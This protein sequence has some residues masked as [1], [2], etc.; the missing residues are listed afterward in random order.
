MFIREAKVEDAASLLDLLHRLDRESKFML[1]EPGERETTL[2]EQKAILESFSNSSSKTMLIACEDEQVVGFVIGVGNT[3]NRNKH[4][5][6][7]VIGVQQRSAGKGIGR[8]LLID[9]E[10]WAYKQGFTRME[11]TVMCHNERA[12]GLYQ[13]RGFEIEGVKRRSLIADGEYVDEYYMSKL[14]EA[15]HSDQERQASQKKSQSVA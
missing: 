9:L 13:S 8:Q 3:L 14:F 12:K 6:F 1:V 2:E 11:L 7:C 5:L 15:C 10:I 4:S